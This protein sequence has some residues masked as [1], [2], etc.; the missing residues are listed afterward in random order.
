MISCYQCNSIHWADAP[1]HRVVHLLIANCTAKYQ[2]VPPQVTTW[3]TSCPL[4]ESVNKR[5]VQSCCFM[6]ALVEYDGYTTSHWLAA[7]VIWLAEWLTAS[8]CMA[9]LCMCVFV[10]ELSSLWSKLVG[11]VWGLTLFY[12]HQMNRVNSRNDSSIDIIV[13][14]T[15]TMMSMLLSLREFTRFI[16]W[17]Q[18]SVSPQTKPTN[19]G[20]KSAYIG[21]YSLRS[22]SPCYSSRNLTLILPSHGG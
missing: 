11:L 3:T 19:L 16:W 20:H 18:N 10:A 13:S 6:W 15:L 9:T 17:M 8:D 22:L 7:F 2:S 12:I 14:K 4:I 5:I 1:Y 21:C